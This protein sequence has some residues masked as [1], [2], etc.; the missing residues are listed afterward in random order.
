[1]T[2]ETKKESKKENVQQVKAKEYKTRL[3]NEK[4]AAERKNK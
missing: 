1:M 3:A 2:K 4:K